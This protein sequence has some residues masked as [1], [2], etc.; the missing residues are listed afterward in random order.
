MDTGEAFRR[1]EAGLPVGSRARALFVTLSGREE[2]RSERGGE[3]YD[4]ERVVQAYG[5]ARKPKELKM[6]KQA[7]EQGFL[8]KCTERNADPAYV[9]KTADRLAREFGA[10]MVGALP[11]AIGQHLIPGI[12]VIGDSASTAGS[13]TGLLRGSDKANIEQDL[14]R[15]AWR[16]AIP[17]YGS[18]RMAHRARAV[19]DESDRRGGEHPYANLVAERLSS[20][21]AILAGAGVGAGAGA[22]A[23]DKMPTLWGGHSNVESGAIA[24][25]GIAAVIPL[26]TSTVA[27]IRKRRTLDEQ[28]DVEGGGRALAKYVVPGLGMYDSWKRLGASRNIYKHPDDKQ[29]YDQGYADI[30]K[31]AQIGVQPAPED[32]PNAGFDSIQSQGGTPSQYHIPTL[33][34]A[35]KIRHFLSGAWQFAGEH[36]LPIALGAAGALGTAIPAYMTHRSHQKL[37]QVL[38]AQEEQKRKE[39]EQLALLQQIPALKAAADMISKRIN[40]R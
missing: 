27:A 13:L 35:E 30:M 9:V 29:A 19:A 24:G 5:K 15:S 34:F 22:L 2:L 32:A 1:I 16:S 20:L 31:Q 36:K 26:I 12:G 25:A 17:G 39:Q 11:F 28:A 40:R 7:Y 21:T 4:P 3:Q 33:P 37:D 8:N 10:G 23:G 38:K 14:G 6:D 18:Y